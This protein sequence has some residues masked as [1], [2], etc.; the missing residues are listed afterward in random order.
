MNGLDYY[1]IN[2]LKRPRWGLMLHFLNDSVIQ[3]FMRSAMRFMDN[4]SSYL[5]FVT[6]MLLSTNYLSLYEVI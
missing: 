3:Y 6:E 1:S 4:S 2:S 5:L